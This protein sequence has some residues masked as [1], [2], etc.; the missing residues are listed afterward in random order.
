MFFTIINVIASIF[1]M[2]T[3]KKPYEHLYTSL[4]EIGL[5]D[6]AVELYQ[7][8][9]RGEVPITEIAKNLGV[10]RPNVYARIKELDKQGLIKP[11][12]EEVGAKRKHFSVEPPSVV[13]E[14]LRLKKEKLSQLDSSFVLEMPDLLALYQQRDSPTKIKVMQGREQYLKILDKSLEES[15]SEILFFGSF[16]DFVQFVSWERE[17]W[18]INKRV[19]K[20]ISI[21]TLLLSGEDAD[22]L[23]EKD[24][25]QMRETRILRNMDRFSSSYML[26]SNKCIFWQPRTPLAV[27]V[28]DQYIKEMMK[29]IFEKLWESAK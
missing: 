15:K 23:K 25:G 17:L 18:W 14:K 16:D 6:R 21:K 29:S 10:S 7:L 12:P 9:L 24:T 8:S 26:F 19:K 4:I 2:E 5:S 27:L 22:L 20:G 11:V 3:E 1:I 13:L 28:E